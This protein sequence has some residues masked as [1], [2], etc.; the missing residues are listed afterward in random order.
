M[1]GCSLGAK[2]AAVVGINHGVLSCF[3]GL[4]ISVH[5]FNIG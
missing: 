3:L 2:L 1:N 4:L 5:A